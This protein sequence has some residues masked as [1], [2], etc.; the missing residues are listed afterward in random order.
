L[1]D[2]DQYEGVHLVNNSSVQ[3]VSSDNITEWRFTEE[4]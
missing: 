3:I 2:V 4:R 1:R